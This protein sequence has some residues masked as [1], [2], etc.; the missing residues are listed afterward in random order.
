[1]NNASSDSHESVVAGESLGDT[2]R[3]DGNAAAGILSEVFVSADGRAHPDARVA[4]LDR[5]NINRYLP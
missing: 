2:R 5:C 3:V 4:R 1:M